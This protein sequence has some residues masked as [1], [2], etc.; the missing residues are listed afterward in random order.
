M[1][2]RLSIA[3]NKSSSSSISSLSTSCNCSSGLKE[4]NQRF[5]IHITIR[6]KERDKGT[7]DYLNA[8]IFRDIERTTMIGNMKIC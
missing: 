8:S 5:I 2:L 4:I 1:I 6:T 3:S 7:G